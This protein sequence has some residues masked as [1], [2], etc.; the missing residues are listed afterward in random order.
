[1]EKQE[2]IE[3]VKEELDQLIGLENAEIYKLSFSK[4]ELKLFI[5]KLCEKLQDFDGDIWQ[6][7]ELAA[8][9]IFELSKISFP[10]SG[11][12]AHFVLRL[13]REGVDEVCNESQ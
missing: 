3:S 11:I 8:S 10:G 5:P 13:F 4:K 9:V 2:Y 1:M 6:L 7:A 12:V